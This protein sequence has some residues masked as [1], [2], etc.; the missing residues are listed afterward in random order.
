MRRV[1]EVPVVGWLGQPFGLTGGLA[2]ALAFRG[3]AE[4]LSLAIT[5][6]WIEIVAAT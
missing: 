2:R 1:T 3:R 4:A 6:V 5:M